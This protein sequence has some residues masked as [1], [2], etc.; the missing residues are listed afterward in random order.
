M[1][2]YF[3]FGLVVG[4]FLNVCI[5]RLPLEQSIAF[6][7]SHC[8]NCSHPLSWKDLFPLISFVLLGGRCRYCHKPIS[9]R[10]FVV[11]LL[12]GIIFASSVLLFPEIFD[13]FFL[14][15]IGA[16]MLAIFVADLETFIIPDELVGAG[17]VVGVMKALYQHQ[18][19]TYI[20]GAL[21]GVGFLWF[22]RIIGAKFYRK[23]VLGFGDVK[24]GAVLGLFLGTPGIIAALFL[25]YLLGAII[26]LALIGLKIKKITDLIPFGP[27]LVLG[28]ILVMINPAVWQRWLLPWW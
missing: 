5:G 19:A 9:P 16:I 13:R 11:E 20:Y 27:F 23:E 15:A 7:P 8:P 14:I 12:T 25:S 26:S 21:I 3:I 17:I 28:G 2:V 6:P 24:L 1:F 18:F 22:V 4:S 10:Y